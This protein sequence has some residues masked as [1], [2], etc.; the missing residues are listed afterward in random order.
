MKTVFLD[1]DGT[2][3]DAGQ[4]ILNSVSYALEKMGYA[5]FD[6]DG[7]WMVGPP[8]WDSFR[9]L[10]IPES[11]LDDAV[12]YYRDRYADIGWLENSL[13]CG[14]LAELSIMKA[15]GYQLCITTSKHNIYA[16]KI[17]KHFGISDFMD[18]EFGSESDGTRAD[19]TTLIK[20]ALTQSNANVE[21][22]IMVGDRHYDIVGAQNNGLPS[23]GVAYGYGGHQELE[24]A[25]ATKII[26]RPADL[27]TAISAVLE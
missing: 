7:S 5:P 6:G 22:S 11:R 15:R 2:L 27:S 12:Q 18:H 20:Y 24:K 4:G 21:K 23:V 1:L 19:K 3:T 26:S 13:Y 9:V 10:G 16:R 17:T 8:L 25:G 14:V